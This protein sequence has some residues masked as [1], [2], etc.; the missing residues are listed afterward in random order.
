MQRIN[1]NNNNDSTSMLKDFSAGLQ[2]QNK[3]HSSSNIVFTLFSTLSSFLTNATSRCVWC[4]VGG[5]EAQERLGL[6]A[7]PLPS[8]ASAGGSWAALGGQVR[9]L[10]SAAS[11]FWMVLRELDAVQTCTLAPYFSFV[12]QTNQP[13]W[14][15]TCA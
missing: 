7:P 8:K 15:S 3:L 6:L 13:P 9:A 2:M 11:W 14:C 5:E 12:K 4:L 10:R 1:N